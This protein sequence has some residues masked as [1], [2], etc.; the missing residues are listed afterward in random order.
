MTSDINRLQNGEK[1]ENVSLWW[2]VVLKLMGCKV[3]TKVLLQYRVIW[4]KQYSYL[5][6]LYIANFF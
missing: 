3:V 6:T 1:R 5:K 2:N 4:K